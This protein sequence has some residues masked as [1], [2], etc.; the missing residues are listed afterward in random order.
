MNT[1]IFSFGSVV[2]L[3]IVS[4]GS[5]LAVRVTQV[6]ITP[7]SVSI[8]KITDTHRQDFTQAILLITVQ[9]IACNHF[10]V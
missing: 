9:T 5:S 10:Q 2:A 6:R 7:A 4:T 3:I 1:F 8:A